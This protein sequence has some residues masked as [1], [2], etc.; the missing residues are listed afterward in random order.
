MVFENLVCGKLGNFNN[1]VNRK[2][3]LSGCCIYS[4]RKIKFIFS[5]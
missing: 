1:F 2:Y 3:L 4:E 5:D